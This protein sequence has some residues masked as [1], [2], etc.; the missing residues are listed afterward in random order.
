MTEQESTNEVQSWEFPE[1]GAATAGINV[2]P[3]EAFQPLGEIRSGDV[4]MNVSAATQRQPSPEMDK[5]QVYAEAKQEILQHF[6]HEL[7]DKVTALEN[8]I[9]QLQNP[10]E[11]IDKQV[12]EQLIELVKIVVKRLVYH[13]LQMQPEQLLLL[14]EQAKALLPAHATSLKILVNPED[15]NLIEAHA[16]KTVV[17]KIEEDSSLQHGELRIV[18]E[19]SEVDGT[20][21]H[22]I[23]ALVD[24]VVKN[25]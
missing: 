21:E 19:N 18:T 10:L 9:Q 11:I 1:I 14:I 2:L 24:E 3:T 4:G 12:E 8:I 25:A 16:S 22:R 20:L 6:E 13:E 23:S 17:E 15:K 5:A 7:A